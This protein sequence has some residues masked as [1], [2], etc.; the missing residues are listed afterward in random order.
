MLVA[1]G[2]PLATA[3][4]AEPGPGVV[5]GQVILAA[6]FE[7]PGALRPWQGQ[8]SLAEGFQSPQALLVQNQGEPSALLRIALPVALVR[9]SALRGTAWVKA[10]EVSARPNHWNGIK[11]MLA[12]EAPEQRSWPQAPLETGTFDWKRASVFARVP[13]NATAVTLYLGLE[14]VTGRVRFDDLKITIARPPAP[15]RPAPRPGRLF[16]GHT[17]PRLRGT[18]VAPGAS[19][20][21]LITLGKTWNANLIR[22]QLVRYGRP[23]TPSSLADYDAWLEGELAKLDALLPTCEQAG[24]MVALDLHSPPGGRH[25]ESGYVGADDR[26]FTDRACQE[27]FLE[28]WRRMAGRY[29]NQKMIWGFDLANEPVEDEVADDCLDWHDLAERAGKAIREIDPRRTLI[30]EA[31]PWGSPRSL[32]DFRPLELSNVVY[33]VHM[34]EPSAFT[35]QGVFDRNGPPVKYPGSIG[36]RDWNAATVAAVLQ[37]VVDFQRRYN[38]HIYIGE[39]SAI[40]WAPPPGA[41]LYLSDLIDLFEKQGWDWSYHA[42]R[43]WQGWSVEHG[44]KREDTRPAAEPTARQLLLQS[45]FGRNQKPALSGER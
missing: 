19:S 39:F 35:H 26:L 43:E 29:K 32:A 41:Q 7:G 42:F 12:I 20:A 28:V 10:E 9:G 36:G 18:M 22:W 23:N 4:A 8:A 38:V 21:D 15:A 44:E 34:Y 45:W 1:A 40:R 14:Q 27:K 24:L 31:P 6:D 30:V 2:L 17:L 33:S 11:F 25:T 5:Q 13:P 37:P 16:K 3:L